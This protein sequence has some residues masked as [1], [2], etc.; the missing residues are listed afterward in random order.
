MHINKLIA[1]NS[2]TN[3]LVYETDNEIITKRNQLVFYVELKPNNQLEIVGNDSHFELEDP[4]KSLVQ[5]FVNSGF[6]QISEKVLVNAN[7]ISKILIQRESVELFNLMVLPLSQTFKNN[8][9]N[10]LQ[11]LND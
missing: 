7:F 4:D 8:I 2:L 3:K 11:S 5:L 6:I 10:Y 9:D 1:I